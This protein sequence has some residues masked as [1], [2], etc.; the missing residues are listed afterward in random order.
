MS[1]MKSRQMTLSFPADLHTD[2]LPAERLDRARQ[3][4]TQL[5][6]QVLREAPTS[7]EPSNER[8]DPAQPS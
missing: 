8:E 6:L 3:L 2:R 7:K 5:M 1:R 4:L